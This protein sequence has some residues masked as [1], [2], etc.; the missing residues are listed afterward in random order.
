MCIL[1]DKVK[2][3]FLSLLLKFNMQL[4]VIGD[5]DLQKTSDKS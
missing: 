3:L 2:I 5:I 4:V 1:E